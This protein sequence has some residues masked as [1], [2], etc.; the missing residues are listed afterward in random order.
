M[1]STAKQ[2]SASTIERWVKYVEF[3]TTANLDD[4]GDQSSSLKAYTFDELSEAADRTKLA[5]RSRPS[6]QWKADQ[7]DRWIRIW[8]QESSLT[9]QIDLH[10][11]DGALQMNLYEVDLERCETATAFLGWLYESLLHKQ[12][13]CPEMLWAVME[14]S[15]E[16]SQKYF[17][18][19]I[20]SAY[21]K[22]KVLNW[23][24]PK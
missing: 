5:K 11:A 8:F 4:L 2:L 6:Y 21:E 24:K 14:V 22:R 13:A 23:R 18:Q 17:G 3:V 1:S 12:W 16:A 7:H 10:Y 9:I 19:T 20:A 15:E